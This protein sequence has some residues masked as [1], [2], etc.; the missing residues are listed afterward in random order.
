MRAKV[1]LITGVTGQEEAYLARFPLQKGNI[2]DGMKRRSSSFNTGRVEKLY[3]DPH[4]GATAIFHALRRSDGC[5]QYHSS[6][7]GDQDALVH[8]M[9]VFSDSEHIN[10][11]FGEDVTINDLAR[12]VAE[13]VRFEGGI[14]RDL[15]KPDGTPRK[16]M[17]GDRLRT[18]GWGRRIVSRER[19][20]DAYRAFL[21][22]IE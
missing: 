17:S 3:L 6:D 4:E 16:P 21:S 19:I 22:K 18:L 1:A 15:S 20:A 9:R 12:L 8:I 10:V 11:G 14:V 5:D 7:P 2:V 13:V